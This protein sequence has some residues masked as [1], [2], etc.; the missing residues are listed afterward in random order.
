M[1][2]KTYPVEGLPKMFVSIYTEQV[3]RNADSEVQWHIQ[4]LQWIKDVF[5]VLRII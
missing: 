1:Y 3:F 4:L 5:K 2:S